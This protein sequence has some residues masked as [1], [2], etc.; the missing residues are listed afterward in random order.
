MLLYVHLDKRTP[1]PYNVQIYSN[2][3]YL[4]IALSND[5][6]RSMDQ[7]LTS[8]IY[9]TQYIPVHPIMR[10]PVSAQY[11]TLIFWQ[12]KLV[13][14]CSNS[15]HTHHVWVWLISSI[16]NPQLPR[17]LN[18]IYILQVTSWTK[19]DFE[20]DACNPCHAKC[21]QVNYS[22]VCQERFPM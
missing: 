17:N 18:F 10:T 20:L 22:M 14:S 11:D 15:K 6:V 21:K 3:L 7:F 2:K 5:I 8:D 12:F 19:S 1:K 9:N 13:F 4:Q 16:D